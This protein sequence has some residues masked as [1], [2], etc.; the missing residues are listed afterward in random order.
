MFD[1]GGKEQHDELLAAGNQRFR[2]E[3]STACD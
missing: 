3:I 1:L 2:W